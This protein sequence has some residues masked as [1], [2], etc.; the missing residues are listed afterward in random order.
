VSRVFFV[1][2]LF[3]CCLVV[4]NDKRNYSKLIRPSKK[5]IQFGCFPTLTP[6][7]IF[8]LLSL[9]QFLIFLFIYFIST[10]FT[11]SRCFF[12]SFFCSIKFRLIKKSTNP[13]IAVCAATHQFTYSVYHNRF[14]LCRLQLYALSHKESENLESVKT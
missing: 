14:R 4:R 10:P 5:S 8:F 1:F 7:V 9:F 2:F 12:F 11:F 3:F 13:Y 6:F